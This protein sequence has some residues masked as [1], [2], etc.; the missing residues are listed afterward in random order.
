[1]AGG[2]HSWLWPL[3]RA[4]HPK[5][6]LSLYCNNTMLKSYAKRAAGL[7]IQ[8]SVKNCNDKLFSEM[9]HIDLS[10]TQKG[11]LL[12]CHGH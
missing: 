7:D 10:D 8:L 9:V 12:K 1:M 11:N 6:F 2:S 4:S 5:Y 3:L